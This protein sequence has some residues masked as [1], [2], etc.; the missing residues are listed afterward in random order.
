MYLNN[1]TLSGHISQELIFY[2]KVGGQK[3]TIIGLKNDTSNYNNNIAVAD[4][5][6]DFG[7]TDV[8][9][10]PKGLKEA[11]DLD[12]FTLNRCNCHHPFVRS[13]SEGMVLFREKKQCEKCA[14]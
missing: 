9:Q 6:R 3:E 12:Y 5:L 10:N 2:S 8:N 7:S 4:I 1:L 14:S 11:D 13:L